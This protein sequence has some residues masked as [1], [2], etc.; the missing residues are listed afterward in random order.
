MGNSF[1]EQITGWKEIAKATIF[2]HAHE[3]KMGAQK[4]VWTRVFTKLVTTNF[5]M[6]GVKRLKCLQSLIY[7]LLRNT[8][9]GTPIDPHYQ[10]RI[11][12]FILTNKKTVLAMLRKFNQ[13]GL[14]SYLR[15]INSAADA[16]P[17]NWPKVISFLVRK[18]Q[19]FNCERTTFA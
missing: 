14:A 15:R 13:N 8:G 6:V 19:L 12:A 9:S 11:I 2:L 3:N 16:L 4:V 7:W 17:L 10:Q 5:K 1:F 18:R